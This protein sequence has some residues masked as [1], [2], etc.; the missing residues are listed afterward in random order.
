LVKP[1]TKT[2]S[3]GFYRY[4][5]C[6]FLSVIS[7]TMNLEDHMIFGT[8]LT[9]KNMILED[10]MNRPKASGARPGPV[11]KSAQGTGAAVRAECGHRAPAHPGR[12]GG[13]LASSAAVAG[14]PC[15]LH[16]WLARDMGEA[17]SKVETVEAQPGGVAVWRCGE[18]L[19]WRSIE[20]ATRFRW[21][22]S[23]NE[24][25]WSTEE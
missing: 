4:L 21:T 13:A 20:L 3:S 7:F 22:T 6:I 24:S 25:P 5:F 11:A 18:G 10:H 9:W 15:G 23:T 19:T 12:R 2:Y 16:R 14:G 8:F 17:P 1:I